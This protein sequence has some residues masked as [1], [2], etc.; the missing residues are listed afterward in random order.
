MRESY[1]IATAR[2]VARMNTLCEY[3]IPLIKMK[4]LF[5]VMKGPGLEEEMVEAKKAI[6]LLGCDVKKEESF[7]LCLMA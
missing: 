4:G 7:I 3:C 2:A 5:V 1:D 6:S